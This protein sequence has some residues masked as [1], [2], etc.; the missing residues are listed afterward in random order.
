MH[1]DIGMASIKL[2]IKSIR[3]RI[4]NIN[5]I[6]I[7]QHDNAVS[8][9]LV[10]RIG[11]RFQ[12]AIDMRERHRRKEAELLGIFGH[13]FRQSFAGCLA[14]IACIFIIAMVHTGN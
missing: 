4:A 3:C 6:L 7:G 10:E 5:P 2:G 13:E 1:K 9:Q 12:R 11:C 8:L 14:E